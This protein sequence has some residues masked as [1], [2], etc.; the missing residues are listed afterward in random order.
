MTKE[1]IKKETLRLMFALE[2]V[3][4]IREIAGVD[5]YL[6]KMEGAIDRAVMRICQAKKAGLAR[7]EIVI[8]VR[9][10]GEN[11]ADFEARNGYSVKELDEGIDLGN[12][13]LAIDRV[14]FKMPNRP[15]LNNV[16]YDQLDYKTIRMYLPNAENG[17]KITVYYYPAMVEIP[18]QDDDE[19]TT[20]R[21]DVQK[22]IPYFVKSELYEEDEASL[23]SQAR[24]IFEQMLDSIQMNTQTVQQSVVDVWGGLR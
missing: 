6:D 12:N 18:I 17:T 7:F 3:G 24:N 21:A 11:Q 15:M 22:I 5:D 14:T 8:K 20:L 1:Q 9:E 23:A 10:N 19:I 16:G 2:Q 4:S 13:V